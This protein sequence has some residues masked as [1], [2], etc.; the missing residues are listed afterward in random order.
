MTTHNRVRKIMI[1]TLVLASF[2]FTMGAGEAMALDHAPDGDFGGNIM[3]NLLERIGSF[4]AD[5]ATEVIEIFTKESEV[6]LVDG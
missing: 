3:I 5:V 1:L 2:L 4:V 6:V